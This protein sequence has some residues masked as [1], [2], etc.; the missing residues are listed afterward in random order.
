MLLTK[1]SLLVK[2]SSTE[3]PPRL[4]FHIQLLLK[5]FPRG[6]EHDRLMPSLTKPRSSTA[7][8]LS[9]PS[10]LLQQRSFCEQ[11]QEHSRSDGAQLLMQPV[12]TG[13]EPALPAQC[14]WLSHVLVPTVTLGGPLLQLAQQI[15]AR[16]ASRGK[17]SPPK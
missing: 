12:L 6:T 13:A 17:F 16:F 11:R 15:C 5:P 1:T 10:H 2:V 8:N 14:Q 4:P 9:L 3:K 7:V